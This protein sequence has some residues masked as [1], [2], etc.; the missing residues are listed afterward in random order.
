MKRIKR[1]LREVSVAESAGRDA[2]RIE[3]VP[4]TG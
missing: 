2:E 3:V 4:A 1:V